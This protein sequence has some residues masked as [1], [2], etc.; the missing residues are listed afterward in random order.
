MAELAVI[1]EQWEQLE[2]EPADMYALFTQYLHQKPRRITILASQSNV[3]PDTVQSYKQRYNWELRADAY[4]RY[5]AELEK[6]EYAKAVRETCAR[7]AKIAESLQSILMLPAKVFA[8]KIKEIGEEELKEMHSSD[9]L[10]HV[11]QAAKLIKPLIEV[12]RLS[13]GMSTDNISVKHSIKEQIQIN[14]TPSGTMDEADHRSE[15]D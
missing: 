5:V 1:T 11:Y 12:E 9:L 15:S 2:S 3:T 8:D 4:D 7:H 13:K 10:A 14:I 6:Q